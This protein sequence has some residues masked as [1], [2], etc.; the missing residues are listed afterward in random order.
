M[1]EVGS[2]RGGFLRLGQKLAELE[3]GAHVH[4]SGNTELLH[5]SLIVTFE[6]SCVQAGWA[7]ANH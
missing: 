3:A 6:I 2:G 5:A 4:A 1:F 7:A